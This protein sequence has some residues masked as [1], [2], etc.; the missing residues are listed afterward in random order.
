MFFQGTFKVHSSSKWGHILIWDA[1]MRGELEVCWVY[2]WLTCTKFPEGSAHDCLYVQLVSHEQQRS[3]VS[4][5]L[6][7]FGQPAIV[8]PS[9]A[10]RGSRPPAFRSRGIIW[11]HEP[12][13]GTDNCRKWTATQLPRDPKDTEGNCS[14]GIVCKYGIVDSKSLLTEVSFPHK[15]SIFFPCFQAHSTP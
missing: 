13:S 3:T 12:E 9:I 15:W 10:K 5:Y 6:L 7:R 14:Q 8:S 2:F 4:L 11:K 1:R